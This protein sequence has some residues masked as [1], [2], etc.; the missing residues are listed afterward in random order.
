MQQAMAPKYLP[1][2]K[3]LTAAACLPAWW[4]TMPRRT[5]NPR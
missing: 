3:C 5:Q 2:T 4:V 1:A